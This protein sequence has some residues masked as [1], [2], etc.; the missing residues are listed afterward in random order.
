MKQNLRHLLLVLTSALVIFSCR[1]DRAHEQYIENPPGIKPDLS[2]KITS[3]V[4]G[5]VMDEND[6][7]VYGA[8][9]TAGSKQ[10]TTDEFGYFNITNTTVPEAAG[11][12]KISKTGYFDGYK[13]FVPATGK[14]SFIRAKL[15]RKENTGNFDASTGGTVTTSSN[16]KVTLPATAVVVASTGSAYSG[17]I[18]VAAQ[19]IDPSETLMQQLSAPGDGRGL[20]TKDHLTLTKPFGTIAVELTG[21]G[22]QRL[23]IAT[24]KKATINIP[25]PT[26]MSAGAPASVPLWSFDES[27]GLWK[28]EGSATKNGSVY[29]GEVSHFS[30][31]AG[32]AGI[33]LV[34]FTAQVVNTALSPLS[35]VAVGVRY[36]NQP[37]NTGGGTF[38]FTDAN[39]IVSGAVP[40]NANLTFS[41]LTPCAL[42]SYS[43]NF[44]TTSGDV[45]LGTVT[46]NLGQ[47]MVTITGNVVDCNN[48]PVTNGYIQTFDNGLFNR[49]AIVNGAFSFT[50][51]ACTNMVTNLIAVDKNANQQ[52][53]VQT[54]T[55]TPGINNLGTISACGVSS[56]GVINYTID[57]VPA[58]LIEPTNTLNAYFTAPAG[59]W[60]TIFDLV[61]S[62]GASNISFQFNGAPVTGS[63][64]E[65]TDIFS[66]GFAVD[67][68]ANAPVPLVVTIT[69][70][71]NQGGFVSGHFSGSVL[72]FPSNTPHTISCDFRVRRFQ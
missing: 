17:T 24:G 45:D 22:G 41:V 29:V 51:I 31:W 35:N 13:T 53:P 47:S 32:A 19:W 38:G 46:G 63:A 62:P 30:F 59:G 54:I 39:G 14:E 4:A 27:T 12:V 20:D 42:E 25:I 49:S 11:F 70:Y 21:S 34:N 37:F 18:N 64:H 56:V 40:A 10:T 5:F 66:T 1:K 65:V 16:A 6:K 52:T 9:V 23:Q 55:L 61:P 68:R 36:A 60:T 3:S 72:G 33:P 58:T 15:L 2:I 28:E 69:E 48:L 7:P 8:L 71:G 26:T 67:G 44:T 50:G 57:G 43:Y